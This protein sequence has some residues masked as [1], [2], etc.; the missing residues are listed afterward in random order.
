[1]T[2]LVL[3]SGGMDSTALLALLRGTFAADDVDAV[4]VNYGQRHVKELAA[5][6]NVADHFGVRHTVLDLTSL[7]PHLSSVL[8]SENTVVPDGHYTEESMRA[9]VVPNRNAI[10]LMCAAGVACSRGH[11]TV[12]TAVHAGDHFIYPDCRPE[13]IDSASMT[14]QLGTEG[15]GS[16]QIHA[17]FV[18]ATKADIVGIGAR[19]GAP[20]DL[21]WSCYKGGDVH[22][23]R[24]GT[25]VERAEAFILAGI[26]DPTTYA[27]TQFARDITGV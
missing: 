17:P 20:F 13:F 19:N 3:L 24:C 18:H 22:C 6:E 21:S 25:C 15:M 26:P 16:V 14:A 23:G 5:A 2:A 1:M 8:T 27:D 9:T 7:T 4:S 12:Y 11:S 10:M